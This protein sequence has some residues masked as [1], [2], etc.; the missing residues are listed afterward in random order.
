ML[1]R[2]SNYC[3]FAWSYEDLKGIP[4]SLAKH[5]IKLEKDIP[6]AHQAKYRMNPNYASIVKQDINK[7]LEAGFIASVEEASW[8]SP[9]VIVSK[10]NGK[11]QICMDF[12][13]LN[14]AT[15]KYPYLLLFKVEVLDVVI[16][17]VLYTFFD[18]FCG[19]NQLSIAE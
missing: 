4:P 14:A 13:K 3:V 7:L 10:K 19:Y 6:T 9:I 1:Q 11:L 16:G 15:K 8:L 12:H 5:K 17:Y 18:G 2:E